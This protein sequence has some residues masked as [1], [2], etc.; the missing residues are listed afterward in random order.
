MRADAPLHPW[1]S[2]V[3]ST[4]HVVHINTTN[5]YPGRHVSGDAPAWA[6]CLFM[7]S[8]WPLVGL[9]VVVW[10]ENA[11]F[12]CALGAGSGDSAK[13][14]RRGVLVFEMRWLAMWLAFLAGGM[15]MADTTALQNAKRAKKDE[16]YT[17]R[18]DIENELRHYKEHFRG[19]VVLCNCDDP[20]MRCKAAYARIAK[21][22]SHTRRWKATTS[23]RGL[24]VARRCRTTCKCYAAA[25]M[26]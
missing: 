14:K 9:C 26:T 23:S 21:A 18:V 25:A 17:Q 8:G 20:P 15:A 1:M 4:L 10:K 22:S 24:R 5:I 6:H 16:F 19:K 2:D 3:A 11:L 13:R 7:Y 12:S